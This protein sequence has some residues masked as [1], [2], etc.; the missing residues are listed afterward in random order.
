[1]EDAR[2]RA[3]SDRFVENCNKY[4]MKAALEPPH[5]RSVTL[6]LAPKLMVITVY[7]R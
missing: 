7:L 2:W 6:N 1:M 3:K 5:G 4:A